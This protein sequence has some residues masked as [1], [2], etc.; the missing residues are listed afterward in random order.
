MAVEEA[1]KIVIHRGAVTLIFELAASN[2]MSVRHVCSACLHMAPENMPD[3]EDPAV[4]KLVLCLLEADAEKFA[5]LGERSLSALPYDVARIVE[6]SPHVAEQL[7]FVPTWTTITCEVDTMFTPAVVDLPVE[8]AMSLTIRPLGTATNPTLTHEK[9]SPSNFNEFKLPSDIEEEDNGWDSAE[10]E[11]GNNDDIGG[12]P[13]SRAPSR[14]GGGKHG[15]NISAG[16]VQPL[17]PPSS[18]GKK[19]N[20]TPNIDFG[21]L[22]SEFASIKKSQNDNK[23]K[24]VVITPVEPS[25]VGGQIV[26]HAWS[27]SVSCSN[28]CLFQ[29]F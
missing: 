22:S 4:L 23:Q 2:Y 26:L 28:R 17:Q 3:M 1:R 6:K 25:Q 20:N 19:T 12:K 5:E 9:Q 24:H 16:P 13:G 15:I 27:I 18:F 29:G 21:K 10:E 14:V 8:G 7:P 11:E